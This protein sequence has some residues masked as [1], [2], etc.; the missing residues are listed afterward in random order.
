MRQSF[1]TEVS[2]FESDEYEP[3]ILKW[4]RANDNDR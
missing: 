4:L 3:A 1:N 2:R